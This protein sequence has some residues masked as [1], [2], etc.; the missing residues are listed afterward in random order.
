MCLEAMYVALLITPSNNFSHQ[1]YQTT[2]PTPTPTMP[3][4]IHN[5]QSNSTTS[6]V[7]KLGH[8]QKCKICRK[9]DGIP[10]WMLC[11][12]CK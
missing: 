3:T 2:L 1:T 12:G 9:A 6:I 7:P 8:S 10:P 4:P 5:T 11:N